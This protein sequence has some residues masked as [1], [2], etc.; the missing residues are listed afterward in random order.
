VLLLPIAFFLPPYYT[1]QLG[2]SLTDWALIILVARVWDAVS[3]PML[4]ILSDR[5]SSRWGRRRHLM[6]VSTPVVVLGSL[7]LF[8]PQ[9]FVHRVAAVYL[10]AAMLTLHLS[11]TLLS[12]NNTAWG[13]E[14]SSDY[15]ERNRIMGWRG[16]LTAVAPA[17]ALLIP[18]AIEWVH[19]GAA[20][21]ERIAALGWTGAILTPITV[22]LAVTAVGEPPSP[23]I[24]RGDHGGPSLWASL[25][26]LVTNP[27]LLRVLAAQVLY[28][29]PLSLMGALFVFYVT[30]VLKRA[31]VSASLLLIPFGATLLSVPAW[32]WAARSWQKHHL[33]AVSYL[34]MGLAL[35]SLVF[36]GPGDL[37]VFGIATFITGASAGS[38]FL[39]NSIMADVVDSDLVVTGQQRTGAFFAVQETV[40][41]L[42]PTLAVTAIFPLLQ[43]LG[44]DP[45]GR[46]NTPAS[47]AAIKY[48]FAFA[49]TL[50][51]LLAAALM[52]KF[53]LGAKQQ[54]ELRARIDAG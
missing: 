6:V 36:L 34:V 39:F 32:M 30:F 11:S 12:L 5:L 14:L 26:L 43:L 16:V 4:G 41:K 44:F 33:I 20:A 46:H 15:R 10:F 31:D 3:D 40:T 23:P 42:T 28:A 52:W 27:L 48:C 50:P 45:T 29:V 17:F 1:G 38:A 9:L 7:L 35:A 2:V 18:A 21:S 51:I 8:M 22:L 19:P 54:A 25:K 53:P 13:G 37:L 49:P 24:A 47:V